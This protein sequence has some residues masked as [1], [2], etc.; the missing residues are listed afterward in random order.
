MVSAVWLSAARQ[1]WALAAFG[2]GLLV[3]WMDLSATEVQGPLLLLMVCSFLLTL[4]GGRPPWLMASA[5]ALGLPA[6]HIMASAGST[7]QGTDWKILI[8]FVPSFIAAYA[9][10]AVA[11]LIQTGMAAVAP[12]SAAGSHTFSLLTLVVA[13]CAGAGLIPAWATLNARG[14]PIAWWVA[15]WWQITTLVG[16]AALAPVLL[17]SRQAAEN[18]EF[19][20]MTPAS[21][22]RHVAVV[23][24]AAAIHAAALP[25]IT[26]LLMVPLGPAGLGRATLWAFAAYLPMDALTYVLVV[27]LAWAS[28]RNRLARAAAERSAALSAD[29][30]RAQLD[31]LRAQVQ[32]HFLFNALNAVTMLARRDHAAAAA[33]ATERLA[34]LLRHVLRARLEELVPLA[35][36][37]EFVEKYLE[38]ERLRFGDR[39]EFSVEADA[40]AR[41]ALVPTLILQPLVENAVRHGIARRQ[42]GRISIRGMA[43]TAGRDLLVTIE[44]RSTGLGMT[45][46]D[47]RA[48]VSAN[49]VGLAS[50]RERL[51]VIYGTAAVLSLQMDATHGAIASLRLPLQQSPV[52]QPIMSAR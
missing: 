15:L 33:Q 48:T 52:P 1:R 46:E 31:A 5:V 43:E 10:L 24:T 50:V 49:G 37:L 47:D 42:G 40:S 34:E 32:P 27:T 45:H 18:L 51:L 22:A 16:W 29:L 19:A 41:D 35:Q 39:L 11:W 13:G 44:N 38:L 28:D 36:E 26:M 9:G 6:A 20:G 8:V 3:G 17:R 2:C 23:A 14:Q 30:V 4:L 7:G 21:L 12:D 25:L